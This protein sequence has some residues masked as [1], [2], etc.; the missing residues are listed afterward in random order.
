MSN[1]N[2]KIDLNARNDK[3]GRTFYVGKLKFN[4]NI[5]CKD[6][7]TFLVFV[8]DTGNE[9]LQIASMEKSDKGD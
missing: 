4:G 2:L 8:S 9:Q 1:S 6:G 7:I 5:S 3:D